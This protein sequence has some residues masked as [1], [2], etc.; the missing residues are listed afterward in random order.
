MWSRK[1]RAKPVIT[2]EAVEIAG[3]TGTAEVGLAE[4]WHSW[5]IGYAPYR[6]DRPEERVVVVVMVEA[7]NQWEWWAP[8][9][10]NLIFHGIFNA[11]RATRRFSILSVP[12]GTY[13]S[14]RE[15]GP[16]QID[17]IKN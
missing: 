10:A 13:S 6:T 9:A 14:F 2:T 3:K 12:G 1:A 16:R 4:S 8:K 7:E 17:S 5:F 15:N 11:A